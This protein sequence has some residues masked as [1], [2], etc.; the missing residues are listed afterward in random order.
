MCCSI[1]VIAASALEILNSSRSGQFLLCLTQQVSI[2][3]SY[4]MPQTVS[5]P[6]TETF[7]FPL[8]LFSLIHPRQSTAAN[9][10]TT[11]LQADALPMLFLLAHRRL[12]TVFCT[13]GFASTSGVAGGIC[14]GHRCRQL[15][16]F[17]SH[18]KTFLSRA[19]SLSTVALV[20][21]DA[22]FSRAGGLF[23]VLTGCRNG[24]VIAFTISYSILWRMQIVCHTFLIMHEP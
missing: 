8:S 6:Y 13:A 17:H 11:S 9:P 2:L 22:V 24:I 21:C 7:L 10:D 5:A 19:E 15:L 14:G 16:L 23:C 3:N 12:P 20:G 1:K 4:P 18:G